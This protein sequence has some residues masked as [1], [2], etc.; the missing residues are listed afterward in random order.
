MRSP[1]LLLALLAIFAFDDGG[2]ALG[3]D[4]V[5]ASGF[6]FSHPDDWIPLNRDA[7]ANVKQVV[8]PDLKRWLAKNNVDLNRIAVM[9][10]RNGPDE[11]LENLNVLIE[12]QSIPATEDNARQY[13]AKLTKAFAAMGATMNNVRTKVH[14]FGLHGALVLDWQIQLPGIAPVLRQRQVVIP[15]DRKSY[16]I[17][18]TAL[19]DTFDRH[20]PAFDAVLESFKMPNTDGEAPGADRLRLNGAVGGAIVGGLG[21]GLAVLLWALTRKAAPKRRR[22]DVERS[23]TD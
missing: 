2:H 21:G 4:Y 19:P 9:L 20:A 15:R 10:I 16:I 7:M 17:T 18:C 14:K 5:D 3:G 6:S 23:E 22:R 11:F 1:P 8:P 12:P 13:E